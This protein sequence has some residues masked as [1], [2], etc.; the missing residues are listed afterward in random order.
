[1]G[2]EPH[3]C[4]EGTPMNDD[5]TR[6]GQFVDEYETLWDGEFERRDVVSE[7]VVVHDPGRPEPIHGR[8]ELLEHIRESRSSFPD[9]AIRTSDLLAEGETVM[10]EWTMT[11]TNE[12]ELRGLPPTGNEVDITGMSKLVVGDDGLEEEYMYYDVQELFA[13]LGLD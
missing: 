7:S 6:H 13:Q 10:W 3:P 4:R 12:G 8:E 9:L 11:G 5:S 2:D 1:M